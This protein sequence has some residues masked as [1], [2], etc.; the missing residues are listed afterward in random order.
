MSQSH[1]VQTTTVTPVGGRI[2][3]RR[4]APDIFTRQGLLIPDNA[5]R[6]AENGTVLAI[7]KK[8]R[9][10]PHV[11]VEVGDEVVLEQFVGTEICVDGEWLTL[12]SRDQ[13]HAINKD[14]LDTA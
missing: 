12:I 8:R 6:P 4:H 1:K 3:V 2:L 14:A 5:V 13:L 11:D 10:Q 7:G 9:K